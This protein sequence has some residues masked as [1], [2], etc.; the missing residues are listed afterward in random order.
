MTTDGN[1]RQLGLWMTSAIVVGSMIGSGVFL[2]PVSLA[3]FGINSVVGWIVSGLGAVAIAYSLSKISRR[4]AG[5]QAAIE[6]VVGPT[7]GYLVTFAFWCSAWVSVGAL[8][9]ATATAVSWLDPRLQTSAFIV[10]FALVSIL[11]HTLVNIR[12]VRAS[13]GVSIVT[14]F[15]RIFPLFAVIGVAAATSAPAQL[16]GQ[17][18]AVPMSAGALASAVALTL[19]ALTGFEN[20]TAP[21][22]KVRDPG[23]VLPRA[24]LGGVMFVA[25]LYLF[26]SSA[27]LIVLP[28]QQLMSSAAPFADAVGLEWGSGAAMVA[29]GAIA[30]AAFGSLN[31]NLLAGGE[32]AYSM[33]LRGGLP[34]MFARTRGA[35]TPVAAHW[36]SA[37]LAMLLVLANVSRTTTGLF[38]FLVLLT[39]AATLVLYLV[40][41]AV[42]WERSRAGERA[43]I[44]LAIGFCV[45]A[46][47][48][49]GLEADLWLLALL[50]I[51]YLLRM[52]MRRL[53]SSDQHSTLAA[54]A[55]PAALPE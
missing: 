21:V 18:A 38:S 11:V 34:S 33:A 43:I 51:A 15:I 6:E 41:S 31:A 26:A 55:S 19:F 39:T 40:G 48:G 52:I 37:A 23:R 4:G 3:P 25:V 32:L 50:A 8:G 27:I 44:A 42:A 54:E 30:V 24:L 9:I 45:F 36:L 49:A 28:K 10:P 2:L 46:F 29:A 53:H 35:K 1:S 13:G 16:S 22:E 5:I 7:V 12:G 14:V 17:F 47:W 20:A